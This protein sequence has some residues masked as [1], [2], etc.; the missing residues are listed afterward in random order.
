MDSFYMEPALRWLAAYPNVTIT[1]VGSASLPGFSVHPGGP[2]DYLPDLTPEDVIHVAGPLAI[3]DAVMHEAERAGALCHAEPFRV[4]A[5]DADSE[6][7]M[8]DVMRSWTRRGLFRRSAGRRNRTGAN[9]PKP[10][11]ASSPLARSTN[12][13][14]RSVISV[15]V[16]ACA[17]ALLS[18]AFEWYS[19]SSP[20]G[21]IGA[22]EERAPTS[23]NQ[24]SL[25]WD[26]ANSLEASLQSRPAREADRQ[27]ALRGDPQETQ[28]VN[29][30]TNSTTQAPENPAPTTDSR[31]KPSVTGVWAP[32][33]SGCS[34]REN[35]QGLLPAVISPEGAW[36]G[37]T[38]CAFKNRNET[39]NGWTVVASCSNPRE[40][41]TA[42]VRL[43]VN[44]DRLVWSSRRGTQ[45][46]LRCDAGVRLANARAAARE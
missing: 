3:V 35:R 36:A 8:G 1:C 20:S 29:F 31:P 13:L 10:M 34:P 2:A 28:G 30:T 4:S 7:P 11:D 32:H 15:S 46:Y 6:S 44:G 5:Q 39:D 33:V 19:A 37:E 26:V 40:K 9:Q 17:A 42:K 45:A 25:A 23:F 16:L 24:A 27:W 21:L 18:G 22:D 38:T 41:W 12:R 14:R 43:T